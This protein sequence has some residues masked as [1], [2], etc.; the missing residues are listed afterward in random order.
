MI[1]LL[2]FSVLS[3]KY[4]V[5][6]VFLPQG[7]PSEQDYRIVAHNGEGVGLGSTVLEPMTLI[8]ET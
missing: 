3:L 4:Y 2:F 5:P 8:A 7:T 6:P 1:V